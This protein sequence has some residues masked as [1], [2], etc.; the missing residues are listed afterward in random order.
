MALLDI[1]GI[2]PVRDNDRW[3]D[4]DSCLSVALCDIDEL[5]HRAVSSPLPGDPPGIGRRRGLSFPAG[6]SHLHGTAGNP[7]G[8]HERRGRR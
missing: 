3:W 5:S 7:S 2:D 4:D 1:Q 8:N 6:G